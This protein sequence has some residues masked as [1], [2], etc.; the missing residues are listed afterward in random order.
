MFELQ[1][2]VYKAVSPMRK[3]ARVSLEAQEK[4]PSL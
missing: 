4:T 3:A 2:I 1:V